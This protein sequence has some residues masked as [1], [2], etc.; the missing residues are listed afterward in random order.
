MVF[1]RNS[2]ASGVRQKNRRFT[3][4]VIDAIASKNVISDQETIIMAYG[5]IAR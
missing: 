5:Q 3:L 2:I 4:E 1:L